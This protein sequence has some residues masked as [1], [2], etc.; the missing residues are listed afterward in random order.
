MNYYYEHKGNVIEYYNTVRRQMVDIP[1]IRLKSDVK[2]VG[3][4]WKRVQFPVQP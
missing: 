1:R 3:I 2:K 4:S